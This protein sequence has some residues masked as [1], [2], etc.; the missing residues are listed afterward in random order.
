MKKAY[1]TDLTNLIM[2]SGQI[3]TYESARAYVLKEYPDCHCKELEE[4]VSKQTS[5]INY[6]I[7]ACHGNMTALNYAMRKTKEIEALKEE[8]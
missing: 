5:L 6:L 4:I 3:P 2:E 1:E 7:G 8:V